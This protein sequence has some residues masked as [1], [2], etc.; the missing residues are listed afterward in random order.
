MA[1]KTTMTY[2]TI[3]YGNSTTLRQSRK[4]NLST[5]FI[6]L[7]LTISAFF[8]LAFKIAN[9]IKCTDMAYKVANQKKEQIALDMERQELNLQISVSK[10]SDVLEAIAK[11]RGLIQLNP[12]QIKLMN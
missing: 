3:S 11:K 10:R 9:E 1:Y 2:G 8:V 4:S 5:G 7:F 12:S 6:M